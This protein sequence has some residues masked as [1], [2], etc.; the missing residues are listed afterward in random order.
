MASHWGSVIELRN[1]LNA[2]SNALKAPSSGRGQWVQASERDRLVGSLKQL[3]G[4]LTE[5]DLEAKR[6]LVGLVPNRRSDASSGRLVAAINA[7]SQ[8]IENRFA[9][10]FNDESRGRL[11]SLLDFPAPDFLSILG[12]ADDENTH[13]DVQAF[14]FDPRVAPGTAPGALDRLASFLSNPE[15]WRALFRHAVERDELSVRR[16]VQIGRFW[17]EDVD[18]RERIDL[19]ISGRGFVLAIENKLWSLEHENQT[20]GYWEWLQELPGTKAGFFL[21]PLGVRAQCEHFVPLSY[22]RLVWCF[23]GDARA[24]TP[25]EEV[26]LAAYLKSIFTNVLSRYPRTMLGEKP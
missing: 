18:A 13:S 20:P 22:A 5:T 24:R 21:S 9:T 17:T 4:L 14:L 23:L 6:A 25:E 7:V 8:S 1:G 26:M 11:H 10:L 16:E 3:L 2:L 12:A 19:V 15:Q